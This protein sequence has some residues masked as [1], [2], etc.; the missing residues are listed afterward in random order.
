[1]ALDS[2]N[3]ID[4][5]NLDGENFYCAFL[6]ILGYKNKSDE[7]FNGKFNLHGRYERALSSSI[8]TMEMMKY[9]SFI[10][11][12]YLQIQFFSDSIIITHPKNKKDGMFLILMFCRV[13]STHLSYEGLFVRGGIS[14]GKHVEKRNSEYNY[15]F[16]S[17]KA[18]EKA[19]LLESKKAIY[20][21]VLIDKEL[22]SSFN[23]STEN[24]IV[25][26]NDEYIL[27]YA[28][29][30]I[31]NYGSN[32]EEVLLELEDIYKI[33]LN[34]DDERVKE[35]YRWTLSY[36][37][38][39]LTETPNVDIKKFSKFHVGDIERFRSVKF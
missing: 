22:E 6:D 36:Y 4:D 14:S 11:K 26:D 5:F 39:T 34:E 13:L 31:N 37:F 16:L 27:H 38:W 23:L 32:Q 17:S 30:L 33:F 7:F 21:R 35:K 1:M 15:K 25:K 3:A 8:K 24:L 19:Y 20:P 28:P 29:Q 10:D 9:F 2:W 12:K 18:L